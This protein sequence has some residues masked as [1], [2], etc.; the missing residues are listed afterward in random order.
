MEATSC[1][2]LGRDFFEIYASYKKATNQVIRWLT[3][4]SGSA[5]ERSC[6]FSI[7]ELRYLADCI[8]DSNI[9]VPIEFLQTFR[10]AIQARK[11]LTSFYKRSLEGEQSKAT[12]THIYFN[13][14]FEEVYKDLD[15]ST[16]AG[17]RHV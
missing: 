11:R 13:E 4:N 1:V 12:E 2:G 15:Q 14:M 8:I 16:C 3:R 7:K 6:L 9:K 17:A 10:E 5:I